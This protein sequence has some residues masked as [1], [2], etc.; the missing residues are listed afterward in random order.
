MKDTKEKILATAVK[1]FNEK[2]TSEVSTNHICE[3]LSISPGNLYYHFRSKDEIIVTIFERMTVQWD[4]S[5]Q[6]Q[7]PDIKNLLALFEQV[8]TFLWEYRFIHREISSLYHRIEAFK[9]IF[10]EVQKKRLKEIKAIIKSY[11]DAG[12]L[13]KMSPAEE[14]R[15]TRTFWFFALY[16]LAYLETEGKTAT[17]KNVK[18]NIEIMKGI[19]QPY[20]K[21]KPSAIFKNEAS[22]KK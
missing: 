5:P 2:G 4:N 1:L 11:V 12:I 13:R 8:F 15:L 16:W 10:D 21:E 3:A 19:L 6:P 9:P 22:K 20:L 14:E 18:E 7:K 17:K